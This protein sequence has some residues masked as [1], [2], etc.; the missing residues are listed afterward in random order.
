MQG[1]L[2]TTAIGVFEL[3]E[4]SRLQD[5]HAGLL[6]GPV[7]VVPFDVGLDFGN[8]DLEV[9]QDVIEGEAPYFLLFIGA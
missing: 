2:R 8:D 1:K 4:G 7:F 5:V 6:D 3:S 9:R